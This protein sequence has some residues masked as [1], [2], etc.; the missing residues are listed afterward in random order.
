[1][2]RAI[3]I[4]AALLGLPLAADRAEAA[5]GGLRLTGR[6]LVAVPQKDFTVFLTWRCLD[7]DG[8]GAAFEVYRSQKPD[9]GF[10]RVGTAADTT[11]FA[12]SPGK[13]T[14]YYHVAATAGGLKGARSNTFRVTAEGKGRDWIEIMP[15]AR[16]R[17][18]QFSDRHFADTDGDGELEFVTYYPQV[19]SYRGG[20]ATE[21]YKLQVYELF[22]DAPPRW[23]FDT[24]M[25]TQSKPSEGDHRTD[26]DYEWTFK[27]V[28]WDVDGDFKAEII[29]LAKIDGKYRYVVLKDEGA[30]CRIAATMDS[31]VPV[32]DDKNNSRH[33]PFFADLGGKCCSFLLQ[34]GT[35]GSWRMW[36]YD[37]SGSGFTQRWHVDSA[38][39]GFAGNRSS[40]HTILA[41]DLDGDGRDE[42][43]NGATVLRPDGTVLW[44]A[45]ADF[46]PNLHV[47]GQV[48][49]DID[50]D[51]PGL[52][53]MT[54]AEKGDLYAL[55]DAR[56]G[57]RLWFKHAPAVHLQCNIAAV[58]TGGKGLDVLGVFGGHLSKGGF[59]CS[60][61]GRDMQYPYPDR[62]MNGDRWWPMDWDGDRGRN[63]CMNFLRIY[64]Q[65]DKVLYEVDL[66]D[67]P[68]GD[69]IPWN[70]HHL[71]N[72]WFNV[73]IVGDY[74]EDIPV[75]MPDGSIRVYVNTTVPPGRKPCKWQDRAYQMLQAPG[76]Y[77]YFIRT[78]YEPTAP[79]RKS[80]QRPGT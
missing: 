57:K 69:V 34:G 32:G 22:D 80:G 44:T 4:A 62:P 40:S 10:A 52:E 61:D 78:L 30:A 7:Q 20:T 60:W 46:G 58:V 73:D 14:F 9:G 25:G 39:E 35:Y 17:R 70:E 31:P 41:V 16:G 76:D 42:I 3:L 38:A 79:A 5:E 54:F 47:D 26:W 77:R 2:R 59:A 11:T 27:P 8:P 53:L 21:S 23:T 36:A 28:A 29:T 33:F 12:D 71:Y 49:D 74:R 43:S 24:G 6:A 66:A 50:P 1:M 19:P 72:L 48:I 56:T 51:N 13:G 67:A 45:N 37:W 64:G 55:Y 15:A 68:K 18:L 63:V 75:Q 65:G